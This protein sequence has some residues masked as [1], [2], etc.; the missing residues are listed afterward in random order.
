MYRIDEGENAN[1]KENENEIRSDWNRNQKDQKI[2]LGVIIMIIGG[3]F[4]LK[5]LNFDMP[6]WIFSWPMILIAVGTFIGVKEN[7]SGW[8]WLACLVVGMVFLLKNSFGMHGFANVLWPIAI[9]GVGAYLILRPKGKYLST[10]SFGIN[11][12]NVQDVGDG[13]LIEVNSVF[14]G[15]RRNI[16]SKNFLGG[17]INCVFGGGEINLSQAD[18]KGIVRLEVNAVF[19]GAKI[20]VPANWNVK[21]R[22]VSAVFGNVTDKRPYQRLTDISDDK[23]LLLTGAAVFGSIEIISY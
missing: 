5:Q 13:E 2:W 7:F 11:Q 19:G 22:E 16:V 4:L 12:D 20:I 9:I 10:D 21:S 15:A 1:K 14:G 23:V 3:I 6:H 8:G 18:I 17:E